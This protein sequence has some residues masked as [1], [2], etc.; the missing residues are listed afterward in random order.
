M[1]LQAKDE[2]EDEDESCYDAVKDSVDEANEAIETGKIDKEA[3]AGVETILEDAH[4]L[5]RHM[6]LQSN[7]LR[8]IR[9]TLIKAQ[10]AL[11]FWIEGP[12]AGEAYKVAR[13]GRYAGVGQTQS[14]VSKL[15]NH[16]LD[17]MGSKHARR[18]FRATDYG[19]KWGRQDATIDNVFK[20]KTMIRGHEDTA[21]EAVANVLAIVEQWVDVDSVCDKKQA[22]FAA[23]AK[24]VMGEEA[25]TMNIVWTL[26]NDIRPPHIIPGTKGYRN[27]TR[28]DTDH[29]RNVLEA[30]SIVDLDH[31]EG[32]LFD[33]YKK[34]LNGEMSPSDIVK[35]LPSVSPNWVAFQEMIQTAAA[36]D[37]DQEPRSPSPYLKKLQTMPLTYHPLRER[38]QGRRQCIRDLTGGPSPISQAAIFSLIAWRSFPQVFSWHP[39]YNML[40]DSPEAFLDA[41]RTILKTEPSDSLVKSVNVFWSSLNEGRWTRF[42]LTHPTFDQCY[43]HFRPLGYL[44]TRLYPGLSRTNAFDVACDLAYTGFCQPPT[45]ADV[46]RHIVCMNQGAMAGLRTLGLADK[47]K[48]DVE[49]KRRQVHQALLDLGE[50]LK[51]EPIYQAYESETIENRPVALYREG[52]I[53]PMGLE[54][55]LRAF[56][57]A[58]KYLT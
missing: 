40:F 24:E 29:F 35:S 20:G 9:R 33:L 23:I 4:R 7:K 54:S 42:S 8:E 31:M 41:H 15:T 6:K 39:D 28:K 58:W 44:E 14:W 36:F 47:K 49:A 46:A 2:E 34:L 38:T 45:T 43:H 25:F 1:E 11:R 21:K 30:H 13:K 17:M 18:K 53:D 48:T 19:L 50:L 16:V 12:V 56:S 22:W 37:D 51:E 57:H 26:Y 10:T 3:L 52:E 32:Q 27:P 55:V 5:S